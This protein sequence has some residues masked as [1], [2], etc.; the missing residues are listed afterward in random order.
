MNCYDEAF[1]ADAW[2]GDSAFPTDA[3]APAWCDDA[4]A[5]AQNTAA[6]LAMFW[7][8]FNEPEAMPSIL[9]S[10]PEIETTEP[11]E[12]TTDWAACAK[13]IENASTPAT[14]EPAPEVETEYLAPST[15]AEAEPQTTATAIASASASAPCTP[16]VQEAQ[17]P[18]KRA[19]SEPATP[20]PQMRK[21][22]RS[23][24]IR[25]TFADAMAE[26]AQFLGPDG[27][28]A[29]DAKRLNHPYLRTLL[30]RALFNDELAR[31]AATQR[32][33]PEEIAFITEQA[34][35]EFAR[36]RAQYGHTDREDIR[37]KIYETYRPGVNPP[38]V[39][40]HR[41][42]PTV[43]VLYLSGRKYDTWSVELKA[44]RVADGEDAVVPG[45]ECTIRAP[46]KTNKPSHNKRH[47]K[48]NVA[49]F[50]AKKLSDLELQ[51]TN[52]LLNFVNVK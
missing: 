46:T 30:R 23:E 43:D 16:F 15:P 49:H 28:L 31:F 11:G 41:R 50:A 20:E 48:L 32:L 10:T 8:V 29:E 52:A 27:F 35:H 2:C 33:T 51:R 34:W 42:V 12:A 25:P 4:A 40:A 45:I 36:H 39:P 38:A 3:E 13:A 22:A 9:L 26:Q 1:A 17:E 6:D 19:R 37:A 18:A 7:S 21:R 5:D 14:C 24:P 47:A 44:E